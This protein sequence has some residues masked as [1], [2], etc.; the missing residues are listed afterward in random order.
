MNKFSVSKKP[1]FLCNRSVL[2]KVSC[3]NVNASWR[4]C[5]KGVFSLLDLCLAGNV[6]DLLDDFTGLFNICLVP[7]SDESSDGVS[8]ETSE[9]D[10]DKE[11]EKIQ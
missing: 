5:F 10:E 4:G 2:S 9:D 6:D 11:S 3:F 1:Q 7:E 8:N